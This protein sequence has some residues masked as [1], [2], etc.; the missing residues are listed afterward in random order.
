MVENV[1]NAVLAR[2]ASRDTIVTLPE[3]KLSR[4]P[5]PLHP[6]G[7]PLAGKQLAPT[8]EIDRA[9]DN[10]GHPAACEWMANLD[11]GFGCFGS[12]GGIEADGALMTRQI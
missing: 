5:L 7:A 1:Q 11:P 6:A 10:M 12:Q 3:G 8:N 9:Q 2:Y 4:H